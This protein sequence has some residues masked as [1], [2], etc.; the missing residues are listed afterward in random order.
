MSKKLRTQDLWYIWNDPD[1]L[2]QRREAGEELY[3][4]VTHG[5]KQPDW[6]PQERRKF[7]DWLEGGTKGDKDNDNQ[8]V[9]RTVNN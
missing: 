2:G 8:G 1:Y 4:R 6:T 7:L 9:A 5:E 3:D